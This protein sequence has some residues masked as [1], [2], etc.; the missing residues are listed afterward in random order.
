MSDQTSSA[1]APGTPLVLLH[2][3]GPPIRSRK[4]PDGREADDIIRV[5]TRGELND[6][7]KSEHQ[8]DLAAATARTK[9]RHE[10]EERVRALKLSSDGLSD[11]ERNRRARKRAIQAEQFRAFSSR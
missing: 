6:R 2:D 8:A 3:G 11:D 5:A 10:A 1:P 9:E 4:D 7:S